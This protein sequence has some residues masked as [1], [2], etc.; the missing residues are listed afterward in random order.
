MSYFKYKLCE[1]ITCLRIAIYR[2]DTDL[3][4]RFC[5][6]HKLQGMK[7][8]KNRVCYFP[9]CDRKALYGYSTILYCNKHK[10]KGMKNIRSSI[11]R[12]PD[13]MN[14][15]YY[16]FKGKTPL[17]CRLHKK[18]GMVT[19]CVA[20]C[21]NQDCNKIACFN[22]PWKRGTREYLFCS[23]HKLEGMVNIRTK[24]C[25]HEGCTNRAIYGMDSSCIL[26]CK[27][28]KSENMKYYA[29]M[30]KKC[31]LAGC[32]KTALYN[33]EGEKNGIFCREHKLADMINVRRKTCKESGCNKAPS[34]NYKGSG[35][36]IFCKE[37]KK[38]GMV[39]VTKKLCMESDCAKTTIYGEEGQRKYCKLHK[40]EDALVDNKEDFSMFTEG[41][42]FK[43][44]IEQM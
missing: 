31:S 21:I 17:F 35:S 19:S 29:S 9:G 10:I 7:S 20:R 11:C 6:L 22:Y 18:E 13:C 1:D 3:E 15:A 24:I 4:P 43:E 25:L 32:N 40:K 26:Y 34:F 23:E 28:H 8:I 12:Y 16:N 41:D 5:P 33:Y 37:H 2:S 42:G 39:N 36:A 38:E 14:R 44:F 27:L 30:Y